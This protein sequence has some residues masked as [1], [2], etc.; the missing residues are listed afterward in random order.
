MD[1]KVLR[2]GIPDGFAADELKFDRKSGLGYLTKEQFKDVCRK[3]HNVR[4]SG[5]AALKVVA[6]DKACDKIEAEETGKLLQY[7][8]LGP[9]EQIKPWYGVKGYVLLEDGTYAAVVGSRLFVFILFF[10]LLAVLM[11]FLVLKPGN[12]VKEGPG[13]LIEDEHAIEEAEPVKGRAE[14]IDV[15]GY[16]RIEVSEDHRNLQLINPEGNTVY[17][18]YTLSEDGVELYK[19]NAIMPGNSVIVDMYELLD[20]GEHQLKFTVST[21]DMETEGACNGAVQN[22]TVVV[23]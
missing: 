7:V 1:Y 16:S 5:Y 18:A 15:P 4:V 2:A 21:F 20:V 10:I 11:L 9:G 8:M 6:A 3:N 23:K 22:V 12:E 14:T 19:T 17:F 13:L